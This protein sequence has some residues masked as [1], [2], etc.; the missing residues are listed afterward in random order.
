ME[1]DRRTY[2]RTDK[3]SIS[4]PLVSIAVLTRHNNE[5]IRGLAASC[6]RV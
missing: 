4:V 2:G 3:I 6:T 1:R 5:V